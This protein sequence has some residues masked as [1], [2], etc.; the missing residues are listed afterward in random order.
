MLVVALLLAAA[1]ACVIVI[2]SVGIAYLIAWGEERALRPVTNSDG[3]G[4]RLLGLLAAGVVLTAALFVLAGGDE[5]CHDPN[6]TACA[7]PYISEP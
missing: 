3:L 4:V 7:T 2:A 5:P 1:F 6:T